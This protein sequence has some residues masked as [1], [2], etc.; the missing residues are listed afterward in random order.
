M[1]NTKHDVLSNNY[2]RF[3]EDESIFY[4]TGNREALTLYNMRRTLPVLFPI[5]RIGINLHDCSAQSGRDYHTVIL[6]EKEKSYRE[7]LSFLQKYSRDR[8]EI[9]THAYWYIPSHKHRNHGNIM[10]R[11]SEEYIPLLDSIIKI[12][13]YREKVVKENPYW[14]DALF[15]IEFFFIVLPDNVSEH[16]KEKIYECM[17]IIKKHRLHCVFITHTPSQ[18]N[19]YI[20]QECD[21]LVLM[22]SYSTALPLFQKRLRPHEKISKTVEKTQGVCLHRNKGKIFPVTE[23]TYKSEDF[24]ENPY[25]KNTRDQQK[26][27]HDYMT[28]LQQEKEQ[29]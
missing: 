17:T 2:S 26:F 1:I 4:Y 24:K 23:Y 27:V 10:R 5:A 8:E 12:Y 19:E 18:L 15:S 14:S 29:G 21:I 6:G 25:K 11:T 22:D 20:M 28:W 7:A 16:L 3:M 13:H 9:F